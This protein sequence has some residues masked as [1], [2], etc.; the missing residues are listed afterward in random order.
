MLITELDRFQT[1]LGRVHPSL[2]GHKLNITVTAHHKQDIIEINGSVQRRS[3]LKSGAE[4]VLIQ[5]FQANNNIRA[6]L[7]TS[8]RQVTARFNP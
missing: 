2:E 3:S 1:S 7:C 6:C 5:Y 4:E 8:I